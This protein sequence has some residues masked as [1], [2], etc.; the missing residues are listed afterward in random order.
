MAGRL[1]LEAIKTAQ[2]ADYEDALE[3]IEALKGALT[4]GE[5]GQGQ[6]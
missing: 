4:R 6:A 1:N 5:L 3:Q 2:A